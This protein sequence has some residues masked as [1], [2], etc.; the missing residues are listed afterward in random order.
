MNASIFDNLSDKMRCGIF[1][2]ASGDVMIVHDRPLIS[3]VNWVEFDDG[4]NSVS[5]IYEHG[6]IQPLGI[7]FDKK[8]V[9]NLKKAGCI[10]LMY[11]SAGQ[12]IG[13]ISVSF[14]VKNYC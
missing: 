10:E 9:E 4:D 3:D 5:I 7:S 13:K 1:T 8:M 11:F 6:E 12:V 14:I 2:N